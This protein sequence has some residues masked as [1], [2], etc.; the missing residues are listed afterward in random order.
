MNT[1][2]TVSAAVLSFA[3]LFG[4]VGCLKRPT[5]T[6]EPDARQAAYFQSFE[7]D[8]FERETFESVD[9][10]APDPAA[11]RVETA[12]PVKPVEPVQ[13]ERP[14][15]QTGF[16]GAIVIV[17]HNCSP[18]EYLIGDLAWLQGRGWRL[19]D[20]RGRDPGSVQLSGQWVLTDTVTWTGSVPTVQF[21]RDGQLVDESTGYANTEDWERRKPA[22]LK[23]VERHN[24]MTTKDRGGGQ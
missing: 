20:V 12:E 15:K 6:A 23:L 13:T 10:V 19:Q 3:V 7:P 8:P 22:L 11:E 9:V 21:Y 5:Q 14:R 16:T 4:C 18:C 24:A 1:M 17:G 2:K